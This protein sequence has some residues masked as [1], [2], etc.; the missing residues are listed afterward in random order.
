MKK[1]IY[2]L[3]IGCIAAIVMGHSAGID[4]AT[5]SPSEVTCKNAGC[6][7]SFALNSG[8]GSITIAH[9]IP[10]SGYVPGTTYQMSVTIARSGSTLFGFDFEALATSNNASAGNIVVTNA[11]KTK[12]LIG[13]TTGRQNITHTKNAGLQAN[14]M[15]FDFDW[16]APAATTGDV[17]FWTAGNAADKSNN[18]TGDYIYTT[19]TVV[20]PLPIVTG[21]VSGSPFCQGQTGINIP[22]AI[23][24]S[25]TAG[26]IF[27][28]QLSDA[29]GSFASPLNIGTLTSTAS[30]TIVSSVTLPS[31]AGTKYRIRVVSSSPA[32]N[33]ADNG[34]DLTINANPTTANAGTDQTVCAT[35]TTLAGNTPT[36]GTGTWTVVSGPASI[37]SPNSPTSGVTGLAA[38]ANVFRWTISNSP[39]A[40]SSDD[41]TIT[42]SGSI[43]TANAGSDQSICGTT[44]TLAG[45][46]VGGGETGTWSL[47]SGL[48]AITSINSPTSGVT[49]LGIGANTFRWTIDNGTCT[50]SS[51]DVVI[52][53]VASPT[54]VNAG[55]D[56]TICNS[57][58]TLIGNTPTVGTGTWTQIAGSGTI[59]SAN[60]A[61]TTVTSLGS[62]V[63]NIFV[64]T[65]SNSPCADSKDTVVIDNCIGSG[66]SITTDSIIGSP[67]CSYTSYSVMVPFTS[68]GTFTGYYVAEL[69]D[70][71]GNFTSPVSIGAGSSSPISAVIPFAT[72][73]GSGYRIRVTNT[74]PVTYGTINGA[75]L[76]INDCDEIITGTITG[77]PFCSNTSYNISIPFT[78]IGP[79]VAP[80]IAQLSDATG[81]FANN[82]VTIGYS[83]VSPINTS[84]P[85]GTLSGTNYRVRVVDYNSYGTPQADTITVDNGVN[86]A[87]NA[88]CPTGINEIY[89]KDFIS[90]YPNPSEGIFNLEIKTL[91]ALDITIEIRNVVGSIVCGKSFDNLIADNLIPIDIARFGKG[92]YIVKVKKGDDYI[93]KKI[94]VN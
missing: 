79:F 51:D 35:T 72:P 13:G 22:Y 85:I 61:T 2:S 25:F 44:G 81:S 39:C 30:G 70:S 27:T 77:S 10:S 78:V 90:I 71:T 75:E 92:M 1:I 45:N 84:L 48:G 9:N 67:F 36:I 4:E 86:L 68:A 88:S 20:S 28:A 18:A 87:I 14:T 3:F 73:I 46:I 43:T 5:G 32:L 80:F 34:T 12:I 6:H 52:T 54:T 42:Q 23:T 55:A 49:G 66:T 56:Q 57:S 94:S 83:S 69:S 7:N 62:G 53:G 63:S 37:T 15:T 38:G 21:T 41:V 11:A 59:T 74:A 89:L 16:T 76:R 82:P 8:G 47:M 64:W 93:F 60:S 65:I 91:T 26:N 50:P 19:S 40:S 31:V 17:K 29:T 58:V 33:G 24:G